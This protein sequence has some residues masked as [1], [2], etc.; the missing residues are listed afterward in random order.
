MSFVK[1]SWYV[2]GWQSE[3]EDGKAVA[4]KLLGQSVVM[5]RGGDGA[6][7]VLEDRCAH[8]GVPLSMGSVVDGTMQCLYHGLRFNAE[9]VCVHNPHITG[10]PDRLKVRHYPVV[11]RHGAIWVWMGDEAA[12]EP[13]GVPDYGLFDTDRDDYAVV[14]GYMHVQADYR[15][16]I[17]NLLDLSH[18]EYLHANTVGTKGSS[19]S[20][21]NSVSV[22]ENSVTVH[23][24]V[25]DLPP[26][27]VFKPVWKKTERIDQQANMTWRA[28]S[29]LL[30]DLGIMPPGGE[31][32]DGLHF[33]SAHLLT[34]E[35]SQR[36][37]YFYAVS[38]NFMLDD[39]A[40][41]AKVRETFQKAFGEEDKPVIEAVQ[42]SVNETEGAFRFVD[43]TTGDGAASRARRVLATMDAV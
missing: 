29:N 1:N 34:P 15:L 30:L 25:F 7:S 22:G 21:K 2:A 27:A 39:T 3:V 9:G 18:A 32:A 35:D 28:A 36:T 17:D 31:L 14:Q 42:R 10:A 38:R 12:A 23:R 20:V 11:L 26:S 40:L 8:R 24:K 37:H 43:F 19:G 33:P 16:V 41:N 13:A 6:I 5:F 4:R